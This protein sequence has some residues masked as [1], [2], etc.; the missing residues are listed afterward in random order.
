MNLLENAVK[1]TDESGIVTI[2]IQKYEL[3]ARMDIEDNGMGIPQH[4]ISDI[5]KRFYRGADAKQ[6]QG[7]GIGLYLARKI[8]MEQGG[9]MK[10][11]SELGKGSLFSI[12]IPISGK[13]GVQA[14]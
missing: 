8:I 6:T 5:F 10:V 7:V 12:F 11:S 13:N 3:F 14:I 2:S 1:Y 9:Y 4:E